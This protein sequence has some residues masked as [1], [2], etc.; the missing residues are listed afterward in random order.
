MVPVEFSKGETLELAVGELPPDVIWGN[1]VTWLL[2][3][4]SGHCMVRCDPRAGRTRR[5]PDRGG[6]GDVQHERAAPAGR[7]R[8]R[9]HG[10]YGRGAGATRAEASCRRPGIRRSRVWGSS[11]R[12]VQREHCSR[13][14]WPGNGSIILPKASPSTRRWTWRVLRAECSEGLAVRRGKNAVHRKSAVS[15]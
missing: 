1:S 5:A 3:G 14:C 7:V 15:A 9:G 11:T 8:A 4:G 12:W 10:T 6:T 13:R 2:P